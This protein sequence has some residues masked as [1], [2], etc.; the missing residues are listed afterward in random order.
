MKKRIE[1]ESIRDSIKS[2]YDLDSN[3]EQTEDERVL[4]LQLE[5][6]EITLDEFERELVKIYVQLQEETPRC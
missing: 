4:M 1:V 2:V 6:E 3:Q 5:R